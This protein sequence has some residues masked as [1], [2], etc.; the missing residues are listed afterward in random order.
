MKTVITSSGDNLDALFDRRFGRT[1]WFCIYDE[2]ARSTAFLKNVNTNAG[3]DA[4]EKAAEMM[5]SMNVNKVISGDFGLLAE[6]ILDASNIQMAIL[7]DPNLT[8]ADIIERLSSA[9]R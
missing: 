8:I 7:P 5:I 1:E 2:D 3:S 6:A 4:G 9:R